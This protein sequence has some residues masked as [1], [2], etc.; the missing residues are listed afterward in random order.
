MVEGLHRLMPLSS[1]L[2]VESPKSTNCGAGIFTGSAARFILQRV[3]RSHLELSESFSPSISVKMGGATILFVNF[4]LI[5]VSNL[6]EFLI[7]GEVYF[8]VSPISWIILRPQG[9]AVAPM[10][11]I[12]AG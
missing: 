9:G 4:Q 6:L 7:S 12:R 5:E 2:N 3:Y 1:T 11:T 10:I 8:R